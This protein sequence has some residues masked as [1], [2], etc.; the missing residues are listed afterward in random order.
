MIRRRNRGFTLAELTIVIVIAAIL[1]AIAI[2]Q[3]NLRQIEATWFHEQVRSGVRYAQRTAVAQRRCIFVSVS[4]NQL[5]LFYD[6]NGDCLI[7]ATRVRELATNQD[8]ILGAPT[9][10]TVSAAPNP[11]SFNGLGQ[12]SAGAT[13]SVSGKTV[14]VNAETGYV[15]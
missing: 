14:T 6:N 15:Q 4:A 11:F 9:G 5:E 7:S 3:L 12:P 1:A 13:V 10:V 8:F 2:P